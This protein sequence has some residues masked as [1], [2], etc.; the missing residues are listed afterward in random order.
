LGERLGA[1]RVFALGI[2]RAVNEAFLRRLAERG[3]GA[4]ELVESEDRLDEAMQA[5][6][7]RVGTPLLS[8]LALEPEGF[9]LEPDSLVPARLPDLFAG[10]PLLILG[11]YRGHPVGRLHVRAAAAGAAWTEAVSVVVRDNPAIAAA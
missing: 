4:C 10:S 1:I 3:G 9:A 7:R 5:I 2:D 6:H 11:R 8:G